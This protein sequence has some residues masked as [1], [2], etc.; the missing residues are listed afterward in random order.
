MPGPAEPRR[1]ATGMGEGPRLRRRGSRGEGEPTPISMPMP[2]MP[3]LS[4]GGGFI[5]LRLMVRL[6]RGGGEQGPDPGRG[7]KAGEGDVSIRA[8]SMLPPMPPPMLAPILMLMP[9]VVTSPPPSE[10]PLMA[11]V[12]NA[13][14]F[15]PGA[16]RLVEKGVVEGPKLGRGPGYED[17]TE[18]G[19]T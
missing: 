4:E 7:A 12:R 13:G 10:T 11:W 3:I 17:A 2:S 9:V 14:E 6:P 19:G 1:T 18:G 5:R 16:A 8:G 15:A